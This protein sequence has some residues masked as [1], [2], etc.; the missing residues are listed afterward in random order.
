[1]VV[2]KG[3]DVPDI[4]NETKLRHTLLQAGSIAYSD[5]ASGRYVSQKLFKTLGIEKER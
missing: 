1:M 5:S 4:G 2:K 3:A